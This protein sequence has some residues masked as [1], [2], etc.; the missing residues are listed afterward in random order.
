MNKIIFTKEFFLKNDLTYLTICYFLFLTSLDIQSISGFVPFILSG[1]WLTLGWYF[2]FTKKNIFKSVLKLMIIPALI[3][4]IINVFNPVSNL[5]FSGASNMVNDLFLIVSI[6]IITYL[7]VN[8]ISPDTDKKYA[9]FEANCRKNE[10]DYL[11]HTFRI[12][13]A[14]T[15]INYHYDERVNIYAIDDKICLAG[16]SLFVQSSDNVVI[17][18]VT[19]YDR[20]F[21]D[22]NMDYNS[23]NEESLE[24]FKMYAI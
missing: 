13:N 1:G 3:V 19:D 18:S 20:Y 7:G 14:D 2:S 22:L 10:T 16:N 4:F 17:G 11:K 8:L 21:K 24:V 15:S 9:I 5:Q 12:L 6:I 23:M